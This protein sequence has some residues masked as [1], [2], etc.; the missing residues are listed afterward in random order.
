M[1]LNLETIMFASRKS[2]SIRAV[3]KAT[4]PAHKPLF[5]T[6][7]ERQHFSVVT[8]TNTHNSGAGSLRQAI[9]TVNA[10]HSSNT[11]T[12]NFHI[13]SGGAKNIN[14]QSALPTITHSV[15]IDGTTQPG[16]NGNPIISINADGNIGVDLAAKNS[17]VKGLI[18][19]NSADA[20]V[21]CEK[22][23]DTVA[24]CNI[25][26]AQDYGIVLGSWDRAIANTINNSDR[27][28]VYLT[29]GS[30][31]NMV[32]G[33]TI[34]NSG[35]YGIEAQGPSTNYNT[36]SQNSITHSGAVAIALDNAANDSQSAPVLTKAVHLGAYTYVTGSLE[37]DPFLSYTVEFFGDKISGDG[38][39]QVY[40]GSATVTPDGSAVA[41][42]DLAVHAPTVSGETVTATA[43]ASM[44]SGD[45]SMLSNAVSSQTFRFPIFNPI[46]PI[47]LLGV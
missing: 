30:S 7:E 13:G 47:R 37:G 23:N 10:D 3:A 19:Y 27:D 4:R 31:F 44:S 1:K 34:T 2:S 14:L 42:F 20:G 22:T 15:V 39:A 28:G 29:D 33:N 11:D 9:L 32:W 25:Q 40:L 17:T 6:L 36:F 45:T 46:V 41:N 21:L 8:V 12:I 26:G 18:I 35:M 38:E 43:T 16:S 24:H 5:E